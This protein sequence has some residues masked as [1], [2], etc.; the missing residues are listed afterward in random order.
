MIKITPDEVRK[1]QGAMGKLDDLEFLHSERDGAIVVTATRKGVHVC[2]ACSE[3]YLPGDKNLRM[4]EQT[5]GG[6]RIAIHA[7][8][9]MGT[10]RT[11]FWD[12]ARS[13][14]L[15][16]SMAAVARQSR[17]LEKA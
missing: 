4:V 8:C 12:V 5:T 3:P 11:Q 17:T 15:R 14:E 9:A 10:S 16:R 1:A 7:K 6:T 2:W 13:L